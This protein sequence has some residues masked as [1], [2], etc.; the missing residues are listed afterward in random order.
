V[1]EVY[2]LE[3]SLEERDAYNSAKEAT[4]ALFEEA[5]SSGIQGRKSFNALS[6]LNF[7]R[8][9][10][11]LGVSGHYRQ[12]S[13]GSAV[14]RALGCFDQS[15]SPDCFRE[16]VLDGSATCFQ[17]GQALLE[18]FLEGLSTP[19]LACHECGFES[20]SDQLPYPPREQSTLSAVSS[21]PSTTGEEA[22]NPI[23][24]QAMPTKIKTLVADLSAK[25]PEDK[26]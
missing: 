20:V 1:D 17:C 6:R 23:L 5:I 24:S 25:S 2:Y 13:V 4:V 14:S 26:W 18:D 21:P 19:N 3:F 16:E 7:L 8:L 22:L 12:N 10:C 9:F 15:N 11:N